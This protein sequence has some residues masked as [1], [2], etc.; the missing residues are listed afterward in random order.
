MSIWLMSKTLA[1]WIT[2]ATANQEIWMESQQVDIRIPIRSGR[3]GNYWLISY[4]KKIK[5]FFFIK[6]YKR[7]DETLGILFSYFDRDSTH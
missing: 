7:R 6:L 5:E 3:W 2:E 4:F 1:P